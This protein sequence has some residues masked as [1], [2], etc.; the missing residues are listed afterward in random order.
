MATDQE[1][2]DAA[3]SDPAQLPTEASTEPT[4]LTTPEPET[5]AAPPAVEDDKTAYVPPWR[6]REESEARRALETKN[7]ELERQFNE[8]KAQINPPKAPDPFENPDEFVDARV[9]AAVDAQIGQIQRQ[10]TYNNHVYAAEKFGQDVVNK[11][12][13]W[14]DATVKGP[15]RQEVMSA[16]NPFAAVVH[17]QRRAEAMQE[18]GDDPAAYKEQLRAKLLADPEFLAQAVEAARGVSRAPAAPALRGA[19]AASHAAAVAKA[20][21]NP[22]NLPS[23]SR[24]GTAGLSNGQ[25]HPD[26]DLTDQELFH[27]FTAG[28]R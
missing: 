15:A 1:L 28:A 2:F 3:V 8:L 25:T 27:K 9:K 10:M 14:F 24:V 18:I 7:A 11:A 16:P 12:I 4:P 13:E 19:A 5:P 21:P 17:A 20:A 6:L 22:I 26:A 23:L